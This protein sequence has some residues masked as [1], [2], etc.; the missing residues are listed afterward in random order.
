MTTRS[1]AELPESW[2]PALIDLE[3]ALEPVARRPRRFDLAARRWEASEPTLTGL[4][5][6]TTFAEPGAL[7]EAQARA[8]IRVS[9]TADPDAEWAGWALIWQFAPG[10]MSIVRH[11]AR[12][13][14]SEGGRAAACTAVAE[15]WRQIQRIDLE[16]NRASIFYALLARARRAVVPSVHGIT[17]ADRLVWSLV[18]PAELSGH[19]DEVNGT[20]RA[21]GEGRSSNP[22]GPSRVLRQ[23][24]DPAT[25]GA[26]QAIEEAEW[27]ATLEALG[28][29]LADTLTADLVADLGWNRDHVHFPRRQARLRAYMQQRI[30]NADLGH[31]PTA[32]EIANGIDAPFQ[33]V[34]DL[35]KSVNRV[36][37]DDAGRY[38]RTVLASIDPLRAAAA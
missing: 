8:L 11:E 36:L 23:L 32:A 29:D 7:S 5:A 27:G 13:G 14:G 2:R 30:A 6:A 16:T 38:R 18:D 26:D 35:H 3:R 21:A 34:R 20:K 4:A 10:I 17:A 28:D 15:L 25:D 19:D 1:L 12:V 37:R 24:W 9:R 31:A 33:S 22:L